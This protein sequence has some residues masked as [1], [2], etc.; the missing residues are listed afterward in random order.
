MSFEIVSDPQAVERQWEGLSEATA[1]PP[2]FRPGWV[3]PWWRAFGGGSLVL[4]VLRDDGNV[5]ALVPLSKRLGV[6][7][8]TSNWHTPSFG[9][10]AES[11]ES[12]SRLIREVTSF[13]A[14]QLAMY[15]VER[16]GPDDRALKAEV[17]RGRFR[18][19]E[20]V[21]E[22]SPYVS[23]GGGWDAY[24]SGLGRKLK[25]ELRRRRRRFE[26][27]G[28]L[29]ISVSAGGSDLDRL[30]D[31]G[32]AV[33][34][35]GWKGSRGSAIASEPKTRAFYSEVAHWAAGRRWLR[36]AFLR[37]D[38]KALAFDY[39]I[40]FG[41]S[42]YLL[43]TGFDPAWHKLGPGMLLRYEMLRR[44]F[45]AGLESYE[46]LGRDEPWK[47]QWAKDLRPRL[48]LQ[49]F[50]SVKGLIDW[51]AWRYGR[52]LVKRLLAFAKK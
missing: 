13:G 43:K 7:R 30:L 26:E 6:L 28:S 20:R 5:S 14:R 38:G 48:V 29:Q 27:S 15:F 9:V 18:L 37:V 49:L 25:S 44:C 10:V 24:E 12:R 21:L 45:E 19:L 8:S 33:E 39:A 3:L 2:W 42:H 50:P 36:L 1:A 40:E 32:F 34:A 17:E 35:A 31:E 11:D 22:R 52:P 41:G 47:L 23:T 4:A 16:G 46:F 51:S